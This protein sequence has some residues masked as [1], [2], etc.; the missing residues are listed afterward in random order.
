MRV[1]YPE[2]VRALLV[3]ALVGGTVSAEPFIENRGA[4][5]T[6]SPPL[7]LQGADIAA[8]EANRSKLDQMIADAR[9]PVERATYVLQRADGEA[10]RGLREFELEQEALTELRLMQDPVQRGEAVRARTNHQANA[11]TAFTRAINDY[12][13]VFC[14]VREIDR[15]IKCK[16]PAALRNWFGADGMLFRFGYVLR[17]QGVSDQMMVVYRRL[18]TDYPRSRFANEA[19]LELGER[20][21]S[22]GQFGDAVVQFAAVSGD[23]PTRMR[24]F[25]EYK[26]AWALQGHKRYREAFAAFAAAVAIDPESDQ[27]RLIRDSLVYPYF[28]YGKQAEAYDAFEAA[29]PGHGLDVADII[30]QRWANTG[31]VDKSLPMHR[32]LLRRAP[33]DPRICRWQ[34]MVV[35]HVNAAKDLPGMVLE[36][37]RLVGVLERSRMLGV[38]RDAQTRCESI[39]KILTLGVA[40][41]YASQTGKSVIARRLFDLYVRAFPDDPELPRALK[42]RASL[43]SGCEGPGCAVE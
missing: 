11:K 34:E 14:E 7:E 38:D 24:V 35:T 10:A 33:N 13:H 6:T 43:P 17:I 9:D 37:E 22:L 40:R 15:G 42:D 16:Q 12:L 1:S 31:A 23:A 8:I 27:A 26:R 28:E 30:A 5:Y 20:S 2:A 32:E 18:V 21:H 25:A 36:A 4:G 41:S 19:H 39:T 29:T 3:V